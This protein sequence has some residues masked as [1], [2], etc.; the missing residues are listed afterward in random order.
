M[1]KVVV[2]EPESQGSYAAGITEPQQF[3]FEL[4]YSVPKGKWELTVNKNSTGIW[5]KWAVVEFHQSFEETR[6]GVMEYLHRTFDVG[7]TFAG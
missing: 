1:P 4:A 2:F 7:T 5:V 3:T 6:V